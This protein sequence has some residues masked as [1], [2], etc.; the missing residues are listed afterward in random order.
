V[1]A[2]LTPP[3]PERC[4]ARVPGPGP[5]ALGGDLGDPNDGWRVRCKNEPTVFAVE[6]RPGDDGQIGSMSL[7]EGCK[8]EMLR[9]LGDDFANFTPIEKGKQG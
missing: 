9:Q 8:A 4:Q 2:K 6:K 3:D 1:T 7:C 5:F